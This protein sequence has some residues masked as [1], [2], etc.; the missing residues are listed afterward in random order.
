MSTYER[1]EPSF[2]RSLDALPGVADECAA[3]DPLGRPGV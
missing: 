1:V 3:G 2:E